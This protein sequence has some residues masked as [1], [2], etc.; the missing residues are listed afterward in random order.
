MEGYKNLISTVTRVEDFWS[1]TNLIIHF[2]TILL[3]TI[4]KLCLNGSVD[5]ESVCNAGDV[6]SIPGW[7]DF[8]THSRILAWEIPWTVVGYSPKS[9]KK[10]DMTEWLHVN[11]RNV[12]TKLNYFSLK[13][14]IL[15]F[16]MNYLYSDSKQWSSIENQNEPGLPVCH[17][18][19]VIS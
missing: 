15:K 11:V 14:N 4:N 8:A 9:H 2:I 18:L 10:S 19:M 6:G 13:R 1:V 7:E 3:I 16:I 12:F 17:S 5:K